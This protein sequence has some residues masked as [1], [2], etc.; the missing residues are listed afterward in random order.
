MARTPIRKATAP[1][2][3]EV[4][5]EQ[6]EW[7]R[8]A[9]LQ[10][11]MDGFLQM[12]MQGRLL[13][14]NDAY[15][16]MS[17]YSEPELLTMRVPDL[18]SDGGP[19][20]VL[21]RIE[22][23]VSRG[24][25]RFESRHRRKDGRVLDV[26]VGVQYRPEEGG[27]LAAFLR[28]IT[29]RKRTDEAIRESEARFRVIFEHA[30]EAIHLNDSE[31]RIL[32]VNPR[33]CELMGYSSGELLAMRVSELQAPEV[34]G[35]SGRVVMDELARHGDS[36][37]ESVNLHRSGRRIPVEV[38]VA[39]IESAKGDMYVSIVRDITERKQ[40]FE[41]LERSLEEKE[42]L[43]REV[44]HRVKN[45]LNII[46]S[47]LNL[48]SSLIQSPEQAMT[49]F[50]NSRDR[51]LAMALVHEELYESRDYARVD[52]SEYMG[53]LSRQMLQAYSPEGSIS[54]NARSEDIVLSVSASIPCGLILNELITNA[55]KYAFPKG[56]PG[57]IDVALRR[58][59]AGHLELSVSDDGIGMHEA[60]EGK[61]RGSLGLTLVRLLAEQLGGTME[62]ASSK[63]T[64][65]RIRFPEEEGALGARG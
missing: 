47:L 25:G 60:R 10:T 30:S 4:R 31:D 57:S 29:L 18:E 16:Q 26:E 36:A 6:G 35:Q 7:R 22:D 2:G 15:C 61:G 64:S 21:A 20:T 24:E 42:V 40:A 58:A 53:K 59:D 5:L 41:L 37:F 32:Q 45:N 3:E 56:G 14:V 65:C 38:S 27:R 43:L 49:A 9:I 17:G 11:A 52:M 51:I 28:D 39:R 1:A 54:L 46:S 44:H 63:G 33:M 34:R 48:Q 13:E 8:R 50:E 55:F 62:I 23:I 12:D 19:D